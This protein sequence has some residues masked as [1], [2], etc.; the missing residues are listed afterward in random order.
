MLAKLVSDAKQKELYPE[1]P[2]APEERKVREAGV[3]PLV[4]HL[5]DF[6]RYLAAKG[7]GPEHVATAHAQALDRV[8]RRPPEAR[9]GA[10]AAARLWAGFVLSGAGR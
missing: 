7:N 9:S 2:V 6:R 10:R 3:R 5:E 8:A 4:E 1:P